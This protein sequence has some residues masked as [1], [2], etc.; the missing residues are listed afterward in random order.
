[1]SGT[2]GT[3]GSAGTNGSAGTGGTGGSVG[4]CV[5]NAL[6]HTCPSEVLLPENLC[7]TDEDCALSDTRSGYV[8]VDSGCETHGGDP[9][10]QCQKLASP[11]CDDDGDCPNTDEYRCTQ[12][13]FGGNRCLRIAGCDPMT[14]SYDCAPGFSCE[15]GSCIDRRLPCDSYLDCPKSHICHTGT[16]TANF[17]V[18]AQRTCRVE[19]DCHW[20]GVEL[21][22]KCADIDN[23]GRKECAGE[24][25]MGDGACVN[26]TSMCPNS[27][28]ICENGKFGTGDLAECGDYGL[29]LMDSDCDVAG[30]FEC[31][32]LWQDGR[33]ECVRT[34]DDCTRV[35]DCVLPHQVCAAPRGGGPPSCQVGKE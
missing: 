21:G 19:N 23:D 16:K 15:G 7:D 34:P 14:E 27:A 6:C 13:G 8:C 30:G 17:C 3:G 20:G 32:G 5:T 24:L 26:A 22:E 35:T 1:M 29:C 25:T 31:V 12:V 33:K 28:P 9:I 2:A 10:R 18:R 11:S 4:A